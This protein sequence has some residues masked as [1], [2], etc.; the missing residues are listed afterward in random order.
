MAKP[1]TFEQLIAD[2]SAPLSNITNRTPATT[3]T[4]LIAQVERARDSISTAHIG[5][6]QEAAEEFDTASNLLTE[7]LA[8]PITVTPDLLARADTHLRYAIEGAS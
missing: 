1:S 8:A 7:A 2:Y 6:L 5:T 4:E 3:P